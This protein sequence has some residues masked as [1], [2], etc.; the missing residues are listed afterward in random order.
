MNRVRLQRMT[1]SQRTVGKQCA[2]RILPVQL[3]NRPFSD[4]PRGNE[5]T[6]YYSL[7]PSNM[8]PSVWHKYTQKARKPGWSRW[9]WKELSVGRNLNIFQVLFGCLATY[10]MVCLMREVSFYLAH[11]I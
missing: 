7:A 5:E 6:V 10:G 1:I 2:I 4:T 11:T 8:L 9:I 3:A